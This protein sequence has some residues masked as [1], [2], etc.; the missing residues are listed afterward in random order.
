MGD[1]SMP[2]INTKTFQDII[3][4]NNNTNNG[5]IDKNQLSFFFVSEFEKA[6]LFVFLLCKCV[7]NKLKPRIHSSVKTCKFVLFIEN[8]IHID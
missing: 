7:V 2:Q 8:Y 6:I 1:Y 5:M 4:I 3:I